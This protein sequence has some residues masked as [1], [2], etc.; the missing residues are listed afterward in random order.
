MSIMHQ[1]SEE[2]RN[3]YNSTLWG[4]AWFSWYDFP[5]HDSVL[6][7][8]D[9]PEMAY[10]EADRIFSRVHRYGEEAYT[11][12]MKFSAILVFGGYNYEKNE[13]LLHMIKSHLSVNGV[14]LWAADNKLGTRFLCGDKHLGNEGEYFTLTTWNSLF[15]NVDINLTKVYYLMPDWHMVK[16]IYAKVPSEINKSYL[17]YIDPKNVIRDEYELLNDVLD[18]NIFPQMANAFLFEYRCDNLNENLIEIQL[19]PTKG[20]MGASALYLYPDKVVKSFLYDGGSVRHIYENSESLRVMDIKMVQQH[21]QEGKI[22]MP[23]INDPLVS[24]VMVEKAIKSVPVFRSMLEDFW[25]CILQSSEHTNVN[26]FSVKHK[27]YKKILQKAYIDMVPTN[28]FFINDDYVFFDQEY[29]YENYPAE[30]VMFRALLVLY[31]KEKELEKMVPL[32]DVKEWFGL[33]DLWPYFY[34]YEVNVLQHDLL[35]WDIYGKY[36]QVVNISQEAVRRNRNI[37]SHISDLYESNLFANIGKKKIILFGAGVYCDR[38]MEKYGN[39]YLPAYI[40]DNDANKWYKYKNNI[41]ILPPCSF[42][43]ENLDNIRIIICARD[44]TSIEIQIESIGIK[45]YRVF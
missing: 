34:D 2:M 39:D 20:R 25:Q 8:G 10:Q 14:M 4:C 29:C 38:Y 31:N 6:L 9:V 13:I 43:T 28:A 44:S 22:I 35:K 32:D 36:Y 5:Q 3:L 19:S 11:D 24:K 41:K 33:K 17:L 30:Y 45:D 7:A 21:Y 18:D 16:S 23:Y 26:N 40:V 12:D 37:V 42:E 15:N 1:L 27:K